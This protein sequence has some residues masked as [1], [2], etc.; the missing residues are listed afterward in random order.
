M[1]CTIIRNTVQIQFWYNQTR[2]PF[3]ER[4]QAVFFTLTGASSK[5]LQST[6][7]RERRRSVP[8]SATCNMAQKANDDDDHEWQ[9]HSK[10]ITHSAK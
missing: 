7:D 8:V 5:L 2:L 9:K 1:I 10:T 6:K 3:C 4:T